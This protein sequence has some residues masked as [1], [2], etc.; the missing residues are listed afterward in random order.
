PLC[1]CN[2]AARND[3]QGKSTSIRFIEICPEL[4]LVA[5]RGRDFDAL[6][7]RRKHVRSVCRL[8][9]D[10]KRS[11]SRMRPAII[12]GPCRYCVVEAQGV[13]TGAQEQALEKAG[14]PGFNSLLE[15]RIHDK[16]LHAR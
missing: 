12:D 4:H 3:P 7:E 10:V 5:P 13:F 15:A 14:T 11:A 8:M 1:V 16:C 9:S 2:S 6:T